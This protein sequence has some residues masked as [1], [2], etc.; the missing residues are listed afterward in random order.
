[1]PALETVRIVS[2]KD[3]GRFLRINR[4]DFD[5]SRH[6]LWQKDDANAP[7]TPAKALDRDLEALPREELLHLAEQRGLKPDRRLGVERLRRMLQERNSSTPELNN[8]LF[9]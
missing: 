3:P 9:D 1:M 4:V 8:G 7:L 5:P 6:S 2:P